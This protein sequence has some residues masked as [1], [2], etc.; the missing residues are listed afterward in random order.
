MYNSCHEYGTETAGE[1]SNLE[2]SGSK[3]EG[4]ELRTH[5]QESK[6]ESR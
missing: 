5:S 4:D 6:G 1:T 3:V 2:R